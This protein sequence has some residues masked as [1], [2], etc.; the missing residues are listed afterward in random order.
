MPSTVHLFVLD[1]LADWEP[2]F[3]VAGINNPEGQKQPGRFKVRTVAINRDP[4]TTIGGVRIQPDLSL[5]QLHP[6][7]SALL[8]LPGGDTWDKVRLTFDSVGLTPKD[9]YWVFVNRKTGLVDRWDFV[10][11]GE[12]KPPSSFAW[13][14]WKAYGKVMLADDRVSPDGTRIYF[15]VLETPES[16]PSTTFTTP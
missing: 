14:N 2:G 12:A 4:V 5:N 1:T 11:K 13:K 15:P 6:V 8:I 3:A 7:D 16:V 10:L 9:K